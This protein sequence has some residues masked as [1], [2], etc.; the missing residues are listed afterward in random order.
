MILVGVVLF[1]LVIHNIF[2]GTTYRA[3][4][5]QSFRT[6]ETTPCHAMPCIIL[7]VAYVYH[8]LATP[9][10]LFPSPTLSALDKY[11]YP[12]ATSVPPYSTRKSI[13]PNR[14]IG[15]MR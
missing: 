12:V 7:N 8:E 11:T 9:L 6:R 15:A 2:I 5:K 3:L 13:S 4:Q 10:V 14:L 1:R